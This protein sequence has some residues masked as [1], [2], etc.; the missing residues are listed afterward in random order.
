[1]GWGLRRV[2]PFIIR[3][4]LVSAVP[5][6]NFGVVQVPEGNVSMYRDPFQGQS[7]GQEGAAMGAR[8]GG[9]VWMGLVAVVALLVL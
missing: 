9:A 1:M 4:R 3:W 2:R 5:D 6:G 7:S 8:V